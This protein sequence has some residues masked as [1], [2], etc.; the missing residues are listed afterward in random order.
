MSEENFDNLSSAQRV[1]ISGLTVLYG[2]NPHQVVFAGVMVSD[3]I[4]SAEN[5]IWERGG[6]EELEFLQT[7]IDRGEP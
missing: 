2:M 4:R 3:V 6:N 7:F 5:R 1:E